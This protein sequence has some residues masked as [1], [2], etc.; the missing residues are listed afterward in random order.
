MAHSPACKQPTS[1]WNSEHS[2]GYVQRSDWYF[3]SQ[4]LSQEK[5]ERDCHEEEEHSCRGYHETWKDAADTCWFNARDSPISLY[6][7]AE[8]TECRRGH[9][10]G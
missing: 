6:A 1:P 10:L 8:G 5:R 7:G 2:R 4:Y 3:A 9:P